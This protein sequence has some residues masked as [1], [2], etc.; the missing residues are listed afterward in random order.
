MCAEGE[1]ESD[2]SGSRV[3]IR[4]PG[5]TEMGWEIT[6]QALTEF[7]QRVARRTTD[8]RSIVITENG[9]SYSELSR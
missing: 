5:Y 8:R 7:L 6:P 3:Q 9:A 4:P 2:W 1:E